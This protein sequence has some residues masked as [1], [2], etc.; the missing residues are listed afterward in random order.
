MVKV[1][2]KE[3]ESFSVILA[4]ISLYASEKRNELISFDVLAN[5]LGKEKFSPV[6]FF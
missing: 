5:Q 3:P 2:V 6:Q 1:A 4:R